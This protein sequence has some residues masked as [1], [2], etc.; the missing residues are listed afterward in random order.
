M[1]NKE[2][3]QEIVKVLV[4]AIVIICLFAGL[5]FSLHYVLNRDFS[6][7]N[8]EEKDSKNKK[9]DSKDEEFLEK[10]DEDYTKVE[11]NKEE[12]ENQPSEPE[13][14]PDNNTNQPG[15]NENKPNNNESKPSNTG[16][17]NTK[18]PVTPTTPPKEP[19]P[20]S[21]DPTI[22][23]END[24]ITTLTCSTFDTDSEGTMVRETF[25]INYY[26][27][28]KL[29]QSITMEIH[30]E[31]PSNS[32]SDEEKEAMLKEVEAGLE[33]MLGY[34]YKT[35]WTQFGIAVTYS[36]NEASLR[37]YYPDDYKIG[38]DMSYDVTKNDFLS[39]GYTCK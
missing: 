23:K 6:K 7:D 33:P 37:K 9:D 36:S 4:F 38:G 27:S 16:G 15:G 5:G 11:D 34:E 3:I 17:N 39:E 32:F 25:I 8:V 28:T 22:P 10:E 29:P 30:V 2:K 24:T 21:V 26:D 14:K 19:E 20:Q 1:K 31:A 13:S 12:N 35:R 18:P